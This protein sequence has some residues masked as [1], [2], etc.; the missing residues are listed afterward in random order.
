MRASQI[1][2]VDDEA[3]IRAM[4]QEILTEEGYE[5]KVAGSAA[6]ARSARRQGEPDLVLLD[7]WMPDMDGISLLREWTREQRLPFP[8]VMLSGHGTVDTAMEATRLGALDFVEKPLSL[9][10]LLRTVEQAIAGGREARNAPAAHGQP[11]S[12]EPLGRSRI[13][14]R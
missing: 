13:M 14:Q 3:D 7:I 5:V 8:V 10:K 2:V 6:E 1:L 9:A 4:V 11:A 12:L